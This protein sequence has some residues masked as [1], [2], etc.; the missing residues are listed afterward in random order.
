MDVHLSSLTGGF[1]YYKCCR[2]QNHRAG[3]CG[4]PHDQMS[5]VTSL[6]D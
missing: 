2:P 5:L 1:L 4:P 3:T 6:L